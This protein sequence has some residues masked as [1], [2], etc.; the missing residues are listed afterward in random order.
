M[1]AAAVVEPAPETLVGA[2]V[3]V[4]P[5]ETDVEAASALVEAL[6]AA[7]AAVELPRLV[8]DAVAVPALLPN[9]P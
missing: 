1:A 3:V 4:T 5:C 7:G 2:T 6:A 8:G 9:S